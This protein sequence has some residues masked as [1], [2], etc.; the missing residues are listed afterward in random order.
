MIKQLSFWGGTTLSKPVLILISGKAGTGKDT[1]ANALT[2]KLRDMKYNAI[3]EKFALVVKRCA[4]DY[5]GWDSQKDE[6][7]RRLLQDI[8]RIGRN[9]NHFLWAE[10][11]LNRICRNF[12]VAQLDVIVISDWRF[13]NEKNFFEMTDLFQI[14]TVRINALN[15]EVINKDSI[16]YLD[17]SEVSLDDYEFDVVLNNEPDGIEYVDKLCDFLI[18]TYFKKE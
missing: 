13:P 5:F 14:I 2:L 6:K 11:L 8:G 12:D 3:Q 4:I 9:Y 17:I 15:R 7:G 1:Y 16:E 18:E 10:F